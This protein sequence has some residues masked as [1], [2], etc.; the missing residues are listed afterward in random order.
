MLRCFF[1]STRRSGAG[2]GAFTRRLPAQSPNR[3]HHRSRSGA[4]GDERIRVVMWSTDGC[5]GVGGGAEVTHHRSHAFA[6]G[7]TTSWV[8]RLGLPAARSVYCTPVEGVAPGVLP[9][10][11]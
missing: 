3:L 5:S 4:H 11:E 8:T 9:R 7:A 10:S 6:S 1:D 2:G